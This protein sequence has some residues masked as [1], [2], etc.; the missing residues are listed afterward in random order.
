MNRYLKPKTIFK[1]F[2]PF[3]A[4]AACTFRVFYATDWIS[5]LNAASGR[6]V[7]PNLHM[8]MRKIGPFLSTLAKSQ[9]KFEKNEPR[10]AWQ[11]AHAFPTEA[12]RT[13]N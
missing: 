4:L 13:S 2:Y 3:I 10:A 6:T 9:E 1:I 5:P 8:C 7:K 11:S 12:V